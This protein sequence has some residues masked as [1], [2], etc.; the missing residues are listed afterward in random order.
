MGNV[1]NRVGETWN[2]RASPERLRD[3]AE[4][5]G[6]EDSEARALLVRAVRYAEDPRRP[7]PPR[8]TRGRAR[9]T[10][11]PRCLG[12]PV[13]ELVDEAGPAEPAP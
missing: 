10:F 8:G 5:L 9:L 1:L 12:V 6:E 13:A 2:T 4:L 11:R 3:A 7:E